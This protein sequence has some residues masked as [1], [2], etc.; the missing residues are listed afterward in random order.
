MHLV[1]IV[2]SMIIMSIMSIMI[3]M[4]IMSIYVGDKILHKN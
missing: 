3:I 1:I 2:E 4:S